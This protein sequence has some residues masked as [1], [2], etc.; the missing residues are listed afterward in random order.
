[1]TA[2][3]IA[4]LAHKLEKNYN[5]C[6]ELLKQVTEERDSYREKLSDTIKSKKILMDSEFELNEK[7]EIAID[8]LEFIKASHR[9]ICNNE[10]K[11]LDLECSYC[12]SI[13]ALEKIKG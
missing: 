7:L 13:E 5:E 8:A 1:M 11:D 2:N 6:R 10:L 9:C 4:E 12:K 3:N